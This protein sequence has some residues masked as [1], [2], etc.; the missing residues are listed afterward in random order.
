MVDPRRQAIVLLGGDEAG[1]R[2]SWYDKNIP[3]AEW[4]Y[5]IWLATEQAGG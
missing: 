1:N 5:E 3:L 4:R 2:K